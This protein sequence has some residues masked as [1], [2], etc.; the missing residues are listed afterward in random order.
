[1]VGHAESKVTMQICGWV[2][3]T[4]PAEGRREP[5]HGGSLRPSLAADALSRRCQHHL[6]VTELAAY[7]TGKQH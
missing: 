1:M 6:Q 4:S 2:A 5:I 7:S 3:L